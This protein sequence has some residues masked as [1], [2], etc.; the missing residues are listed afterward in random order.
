MEISD[1]SSKEKIAVVG[2]GYVGLPLAI[3]FAKHFKVIGFDIDEERI[4]SLKKG[5]DKNLEVSRE[6]F[7]EV[8][9]NIEFTTDEKRIREADIIIIGV[10]TPVT[11]DKKPDLRY[12]KRASEIVGRNLKK[13]SIV[14]YESTVYP[15]CTEEFC[16]PILEKESGL[17]LGD[18]FIGYSPERVN[19]GD[20]DHTIDKICKIVAGCNKEITEKLSK[21]YGKITK[22]Y[23]A[24]T[25]K[26]AE[27]AKV[28][29][30]IQRDIN[31]ALFNELAMLFDIM[32]IDS[33]EVFDAAATKWNFY[34]FS[35][36][37]VG[38][39][40][41]P[42]DPYYLAYKALEVGYIPELI[43]AGRR[44]NENL[45]NFIAQKVVK[46]LIKSGKSPRDVKILILGAT[47]KE[48]VPDL[49][50]SKVK[51]LISE[52][53]E[54]GVENILLYEP[55]IEKEEIFGIKNRKPSG[56][57]DVIIYAV[58]HEKFKNLNIFDFLRKNGI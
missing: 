20:K 26:V 37:L 4:E 50:D 34:R 9:E 58:A 47:Y 46:L 27:A 43:L 28:I 11:E 45:P 41:I 31:I 8:G 2:L 12:L 40:C 55:L 10:P 33:K 44:V 39:H 17:K 24:P 49:R 53:K 32:K 25:I 51:N 3:K 42:V 13:G 7:N 5:Y 6:E 22:V 29:E 19:P 48:N 35:P 57:F 52:L 23:K 1:T 18:F 14:V 54:F 15:G 16:L 56:K 30:N 38:G 36:G 21:V